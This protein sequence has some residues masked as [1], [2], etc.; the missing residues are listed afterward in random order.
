MQSTIEDSYTEPVQA[1]PAP[2]DAPEEP[3]QILPFLW[4]GSLKNAKDAKFLIDT[5]IT[6]ILNC[7]TF[8]YSHEFIDAKNYLQF[9]ILD[10]EDQRISDL[11]EK[12]TE[13]LKS[14]WLLYEDTNG[15]QGSC[16]VHCQAGI[17]RAPSFTIAY[18]MN[19]RSM[20]FQSAFD[21]VKKRRSWI[22]PNIA[23]CAEL[24][25]YDKSRNILTKD[26]NLHHSRT[27]INS[28]NRLEPI[29]DYCK[30]HNNNPNNKKPK[31][32]KFLK[33]RAALCMHTG[34]N[35]GE[36][37]LMSG[38]IKSPG[39]LSNTSSKSNKVSYLA[40]FGKQS[41]KFPDEL[42]LQESTTKE[43]K[44]KS[45]TIQS[46]NTTTSE[47]EKLTDAIEPVKEPSSSSFCGMGPGAKSAYKGIRRKM[48]KLPL[49]RHT[50]NKFPEVEKCDQ[51]CNNPNV[52][53]PESDILVSRSQNSSIKVSEGVTSGTVTPSIGTPL[54][55]K[56]GSVKS[57]IDDTVA[58]ECFI[59]AA[60]KDDGTPTG[61]FSS[62]NPF[63]MDVEE[64]LT[65]LVNIS[66]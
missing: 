49:V 40:C 2:L 22:D 20:N 10:S 54:S 21:F 9:Q 1:R 37:H 63:K 66:Y 58:E 27:S 59:N 8:N 6:H 35:S 29:A 39:T 44:S 11:F 36:H 32:P 16:L 42:P 33:V 12:S 65:K 19:H 50:D 45:S 55:K 48:L 41:R 46:N 64:N 61:N 4:I 7:S 25:A 52:L 17:S 30:K 5:N 18:I 13:F 60:C 53:K 38:D 24:Q 3:S 62:T 15:K 47:T 56:G 23:F 26:N 34:K 51:P 43:P 28:K 14:A 57:N 31:R